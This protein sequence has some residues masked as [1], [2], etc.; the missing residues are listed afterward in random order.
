MNTLPNDAFKTV[1]PSESGLGCKW[2]NFLV[3]FGIW[4]GAAINLVL[5]VLYLC[6]IPYLGASKA[7]Y[8]DYPALQN[9]DFIYGLYRVIFGVFLLYAGW[10]ML[11]RKYE[12]PILLYGASLSSILTGFSY[13]FCAA[14]NMVSS[15]PRYMK[16][17]V[18][19]TFTSPF[20]SFPI[21]PT[22]A[23]EFLVSFYGFIIIAIAVAGLVWNMLYF[24]KRDN[25]FEKKKAVKAKK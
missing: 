22:T 10:A 18:T 12:A 4:A 5:G 16:E 15:L 9:T 8:A 24:N 20:S 17:G 2:Y 1:K 11:K 21:R 3:R 25:W 6:S 7:V 23:A 19:S 14:S 13:P